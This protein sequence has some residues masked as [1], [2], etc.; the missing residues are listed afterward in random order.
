MGK[1]LVWLAQGTQEGLEPRQALKCFPVF[2][3]LSHER[4]EPASHGG[5]GP[6]LRVYGRAAALKRHL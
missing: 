3:L 1:L 5:S 2:K 4:R 6:W